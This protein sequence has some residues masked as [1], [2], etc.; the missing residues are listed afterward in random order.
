MS[1]PSS[2]PILRGVLID[3]WIEAAGRDGYM[4]RTGDNHVTI[5]ESGAKVLCSSYVGEIA[6]AGVGFK[7]GSDLLTTALDAIYGGRSI[8]GQS[9]NSRP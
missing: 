7:I 6:I 9:K 5:T 4:I 3:S 8:H 1:K 2:S